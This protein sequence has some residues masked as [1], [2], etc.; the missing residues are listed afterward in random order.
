MMNADAQLEEI[1][2]ANGEGH[3]YEQTLQLGH[4]PVVFGW[5]QVDK[6][7]LAVETARAEAESGNPLP[8]DPL[9]LPTVVTVQKF[10]EA[11]LNYLKPQEASGLLGTSCIL[12]SLPES[13]TVGYKLFALDEDPWIRRLAVEE[14]KMLPI[15]RVYMPRGLRSSALDQVTPHQ[16]SSLWG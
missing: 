11:V 16:L 9:R 14:P 4:P 7:V 6:F 1:L 3:L 15:A 8:P 5:Q 13:V 10:K 2:Q 12:C